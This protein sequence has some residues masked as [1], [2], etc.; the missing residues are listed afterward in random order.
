MHMPVDAGAMGR[1]LYLDEIGSISRC[2]IESLDPKFSS[3]DAQYRARGK[4]YVFEDYNRS[5][6]QLMRPGT[7]LALPPTGLIRPRGVEDKPAEPAAESG[8]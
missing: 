6:R 8:Q 3:V 4:C 7:G 2:Q 5:K 1:I